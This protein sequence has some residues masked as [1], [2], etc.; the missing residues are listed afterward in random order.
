METSSKFLIKILEILASR[1]GTSFTLEE[2]TSLLDPV[3][4]SSAEFTGDI[5]AETQNQVL[6]LEALLL[7]NDQGYIFLNPNTDKSTIT[8]KGLTEI[9]SKANCN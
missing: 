8:I 4:S 5:P 2:L 3:V 9:N 1:Y 6:V 7:L